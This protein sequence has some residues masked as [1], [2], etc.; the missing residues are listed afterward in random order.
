MFKKTCNRCGVEKEITSF[1]K[2]KRSKD[3]FT[4]DCKECRK[5]NV[6]KYLVA[7]KELA[8][9][10]TKDWQTKNKDRVKDKAKEYREKNKGSIRSKAKSYYL[11][12]EDKIKARTRSYVQLHKEEYNKKAKNWMK[13][14]YETDPSYREMCFTKTKFAKFLKYDKRM[15][16]CFYFEYLL[17]I[18][19]EDFNKKLYSMG[20]GNHGMEIDHIIPLSVFDHLDHKL[21]RVAWNHRNIQVLTKKDNNAKNAKLI[22]GWED[23]VIKI[24]NSL[25]IDPDYVISAIKERKS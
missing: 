7:N 9:Q 16:G 5:K 22:D 24:S 13:E 3:G 23:L 14:K 6:S 21:L 18:D 4:G 2:E 1:Y 10:R 8:N 17:N 19:W 15:K 20:F 25:R 11:E 12:N